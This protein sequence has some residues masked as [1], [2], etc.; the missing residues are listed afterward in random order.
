M[1]I[2]HL[3]QYFPPEAGAV[4]VRALTVART[5]AEAGHRVTVLTEVPNHP[6]GVVQPG[7]RRKL[8]V[9]ETRDGVDV[10]HLWVKTSP[11][12]NFRARMAFYLSYMLAAIIAG[13][14]L[15]GRVDAVFANSP[16]LFVAIA[17]W[18]ISLVRRTPFVMEVQDLW[19]E[20]A[21]VLGE[22]N[23]PRFIRWAEW[24]EERCYR[25]A[26]RIVAVTQGIQE[27][28]IARGV[29]AAKIVL[30]PNGSNTDIFRP[31]P[32]GGARLRAELGLEGKFVAIYGGIHGIAQGLETV[33]EAARLLAN[34]P[35]IQFLFVGEGPRKADLLALKEQYGLDNLR[36]LPGQP[37]ERMPAYL[38]LADVALVPLRRVD[39][40]QG[41]LP[42][43]MFDA[44]ACR[45]PTLITVD[46]EARR[47][48]EEMG[49]GVFVEPENPS[50]LAAALR[51]LRDEPDRLVQ[52]GEAGYRAVRARYSLQAA[53]QQIQDSLRQVAGGQ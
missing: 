36:M 14:L 10:L 19:P 33:I 43:K 25:R 53:A 16:P 13:V 18:V 24:A 40:F 17:G 30:A 49:A 21:V 44:W 34:E 39:L 12:K 35:D 27:R 51:R 7:Y 23:N 22:L 11:V 3:S 6:L 28:L 9:R 29:P 15:P 45:T 37:L 38:S 20:S 26:G 41:A 52:M 32:E 4:Q 48:L 31:D 50:A 42:T 47:L 8:W 2:L 1:R 5:L 46:G